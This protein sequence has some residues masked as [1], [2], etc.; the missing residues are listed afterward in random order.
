MSSGHP[1][2]GPAWFLPV[3]LL[4]ISTPSSGSIHIRYGTHTSI[5]TYEYLAAAHARYEHTNYEGYR[6]R[7][8]S[9]SAS[10]T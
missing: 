8:T 6:A 2:T 5:R 9:A 7:E 4:W 1:R 10:E 3:G